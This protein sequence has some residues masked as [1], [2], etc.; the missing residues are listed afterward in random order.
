M[1]VTSRRQTRRIGRSHELF[2]VNLRDFFNL[3]AHGLTVMGGFL[4]VG[5]WYGALRQCKLAPVS[6]RA[7]GVAGGQLVGDLARKALFILKLAK[8]VLAS[9][10]LQLP[11]RGLKVLPPCWSLA[12][13][14][15]RCP[16]FL[17][18]QVRLVCASFPGTRQVKPWVQQYSN[19]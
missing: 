16:G 13:A 8:W 9:P 11:L 12:V 6:A 15:S 3:S 17:F 7:T 10:D 19:F 14:V 5:S 2:I 1:L 4:E 18:L